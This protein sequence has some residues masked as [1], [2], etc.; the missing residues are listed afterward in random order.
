[1]AWTKDNLNA[2]FLGTEAPD[3]SAFVS[4][5]TNEGGY[6]DAIHCHCVLYDTNLEVVKDRAAQRAQEEFDR[7]KAAL[8]A[9]NKPTAAFHAGAMAHYIGDLSQFM[10]IMRTG[11]RWGKEAKDP[12]SRYEEIIEKTISATTRKSSL[13][14]RS[15]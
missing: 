5:F 2:F 15:F 12:H 14:R 11:S 1:M 3:T 4:S 8:A 9:G 10:L 7:A 6:S 13:I